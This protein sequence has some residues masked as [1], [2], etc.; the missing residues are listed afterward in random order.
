MDQD[1]EEEE[2]S[3]LSSEEP[4]ELETPEVQ[5]PPR[6]PTSEECKAARPSSTVYSWH[7]RANST[8]QTRKKTEEGGL[9]RNSGSEYEN[10]DLAPEPAR[11]NTKQVSGR[12]RKF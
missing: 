12:K 7:A 10:D 11:P 3:S 8:T 2:S 4:E 5:T 6:T 9:S 1:Y